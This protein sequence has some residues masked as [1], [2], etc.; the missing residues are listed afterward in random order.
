MVASQASCSLI[1]VL[2]IV[3]SVTVL[4]LW[5]HPDP[6]NL[7]KKALS[8]AT[9]SFWGFRVHDHHGVKHGS[10]QADLALEQSLS[11]YVLFC[12]LEAER[13][14]NWEWGRLLK[15]Q[16]QWHYSNKVT[17]PD[18]SQIIPSAK[19]ETLK[20]MSLWGPIACKPPHVVVGLFIYFFFYFY[21]FVVL[22]LNLSFSARQIVYQ[23]ATSLVWL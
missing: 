17:P 19:E 9:H 22:K 5:R 8:L 18:P 1:Q 14:A 3:V 7:Q 15:P 11:A 6:G 21:F 13:R 12:K 10:L 23:R 4:L 16:A 2:L 20:Y